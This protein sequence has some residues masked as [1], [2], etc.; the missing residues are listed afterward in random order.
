[1]PSADKLKINVQWFSSP[2]QMLTYAN[3]I[4]NSNNT[5]KDFN[6]KQ[7]QNMHIQEA[8]EYAVKHDWVY[9]ARSC[10]LVIYSWKV[11]WNRLWSSKRHD[12]NWAVINFSKRRFINN[13]RFH[14]FKAWIKMLYAMQVHHQYDGLERLFPCFPSSAIAQ[15]DI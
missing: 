4:Y 15:M 14:F 9:M 6:M 12:L 2:K 10:R 13:R 3:K 11:R 1:M 8:I 7:H 5:K